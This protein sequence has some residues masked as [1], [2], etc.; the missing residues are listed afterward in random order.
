MINFHYFEYYIFILINQIIIHQTN[1]K[2]KFS[3]FIIIP[4]FDHFSGQLGY[5]KGRGVAVKPAR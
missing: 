2:L 5:T 1:Q 3:I 4:S